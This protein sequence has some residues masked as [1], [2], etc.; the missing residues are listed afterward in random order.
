MSG[1]SLQVTD[2]TPLPKMNGN[3]QCIEQCNGRDFRGGSNTTMLKNQMMKL[4]QQ[5]S[6]TDGLQKFENCNLIGAGK[7][8]CA[9]LTEVFCLEGVVCLGLKNPGGE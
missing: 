6:I 2:P 7:I 5:K 4:L 1:A 9:W 8:T 3:L